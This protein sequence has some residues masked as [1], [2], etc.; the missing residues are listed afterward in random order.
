LIDIDRKSDPYP[1]TMGEMA[2]LVLELR[3][4]GEPITLAISGRGKLLIEDDESIQQLLEFVDQMETVAVLRER[5]ARVERGE[6]GLSL[7]QVREEFQRRYSYP[8]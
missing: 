2:R 6:R 1:P 4:A 7:E 8:I 3:T 5:I